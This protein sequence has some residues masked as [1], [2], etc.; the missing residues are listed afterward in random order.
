MKRGWQPSPK[1]ASGTST[2]AWSKP[3]VFS[4]WPGPDNCTLQ[5]QLEEYRR[6][7]EELFACHP[8][9][10]LFGSS[11]GA[12]PKAR[13]TAAERSGQRPLPLRRGPM[14]AMRGRHRASKLPRRQ[15]QKA[16]IRPACNR[17]M[18][19]HAM[20]C[21]ASLTRAPRTA[22]GPRP[23]RAKGRSHAQ[24]LRCLGQRW[25]KIIWKRWQTHTCY[26]ADLHIKTKSPTAPGCSKQSPPEQ[27]H[28]HQTHANNF[29]QKASRNR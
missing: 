18:L 10:G 17:S 8:D 5:T 14:A 25:I 11:P 20:H 1:L 12:G 24:A 27:L 26:D 7:I 15:D 23:T 13:T 9:S 19:R 3:K 28:P 4:P 21:F 29:P 22:S 2:P 16:N 6:R